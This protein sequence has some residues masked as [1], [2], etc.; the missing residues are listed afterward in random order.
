MT[1]I[2]NKSAVAG[3]RALTA[4]HE[5]QDSYSGRKQLQYVF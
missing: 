2:K 5:N 1:V 4:M 3:E